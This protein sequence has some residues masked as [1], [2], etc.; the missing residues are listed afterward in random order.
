[1][2]QKKEQTAL[3]EWKNKEKVVQ[4]KLDEDS[5]GLEKIG[6]KENALKT[7][8]EEAQNK[9]TEMGSVPSVD[10]IQRYQQQNQKYV[11]DS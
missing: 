6:S 8:I 7:K 4:D 1:M 10:L 2:Q 9:I 3:E 11:S 5:K